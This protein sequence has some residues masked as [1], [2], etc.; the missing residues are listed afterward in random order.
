MK[1]LVDHY[2]GK[3]D[4]V[5]TYDLS[6]LSRIPTVEQI[7]LLWPDANGMGW[8]D[9]ERRVFKLKRASS[10]VYVLNGRKRLF[11]L[12]KIQWR[13][14]RFK[15]FLEKSFLLEMGVLLLFIITA[16]ILALWDGLSQGVRRNS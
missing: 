1:G 13:L 15:R 6:M 10:D 2:L 11:G 8:F 9:I 3:T 5:P 14:I 12:S 7:I 4:L 16:P